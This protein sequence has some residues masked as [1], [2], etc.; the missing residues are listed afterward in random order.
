M[1]TFYF[2]G[3]SDEQIISFIT[4]HLEHEGFSIYIMTSATGYGV[5]EIELPYLKFECKDYG[6]THYI[7]KERDI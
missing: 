4:E 2:D 3:T 1:T 7:N 6:V 5:G